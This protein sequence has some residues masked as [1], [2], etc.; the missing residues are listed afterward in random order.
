VSGQNQAEIELIEDIAGFTH[1]PEGHALYCYQWGAGELDGHDGP[2]QWQR[3]VMRHIASHLSDP[4]T[5]YQPCQIAISSG[6][7][8]GKSG[9]VSMLVKWAMD[10]CE[11]CKVVVTANTAQQLATKTWPEIA[12]WFRL[13]INKWFSVAA[14]SV[15][16]TDDGH[17]KSWRAD[18]ITWSEHNT[19]AFA[20]LHNQGKRILLVM[21]EASAIADKVWEVAEGA[22]TDERTEIIWLVLG[23]PTRNSGRFREC[24]RKYRH[25]WQC[26]Q[27]DSRTVEGTNKELMARWVEDY[28]EDSDFV[29]VRVRGIFPTMSAKQFIPSEVVDAAYGREIQP[30]QYNFAPVVLTC[31]PAW[32]G[33]DLLVIAKRQGLAFH[34]LRTIPKND[35]DIMIANI[36]GQLEDEHHADAVFVDGGYGTGIVS[37]GRTM[38]RNWTLVWFGEKSGRPGYLNKRAEMW[39]LAKEWLQQGGCIPKDP[40][41]QDELTS[42][43]TVPRAD[44]VIQLES[45]KDMKSRGLPSPNKADA[46]VLSFAHPVAKR[47]SVRPISQNRTAYDPLKSL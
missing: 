24:F 39:G 13:G 20:G 4:S 6:H 3:D 33:D 12:K 46:L 10:T 22:L 8:I 47:Q 27:I 30:A 45:K 41:L 2:R 29:K 34:I 7:G 37:A 25:R 31:D 9:L 17:D 26:W 32:E 23:N 44:G 40:E 11:D 21:D 16:S 5:R 36:L 43:E 42:V 28:G 1:D 35:N 18:A 15:S 38:H 19:E 14:T